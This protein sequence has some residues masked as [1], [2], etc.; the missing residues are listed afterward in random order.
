M[1]SKGTKRVHDQVECDLST[2]G[3]SLDISSFITVIKLQPSPIS[4]P[5]PERYRKKPN[6][7]QCGASYLRPK[8][9]I[10]T[11]A[12]LIPA[13]TA[14]RTIK[15]RGMSTLITPGAIR[16]TESTPAPAMIRTTESEVGPS[17]SFSLATPHGIPDPALDI[18]QQSNHLP[19]SLL[20]TP[21]LSYLPSS[22]PNPPTYPKPPGRS[23]PPPTNN[24]GAKR[25]KRPA[26]GLAKLLAEA[27]ERDL[28][29]QAGA[30]S[31]SSWGL[32]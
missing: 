28:G 23:S 24:K 2:E 8:A 15:T 9:D 5:S 26:S 14:A 12:Q 17:P 16:G 10:A 30:Q 22:E 29:G 19:P 25:K 3:E 32:V 31:G 20:S 13:R 11:L 21:R 1:K 7:T 27:K 18:G 4:T 6:C